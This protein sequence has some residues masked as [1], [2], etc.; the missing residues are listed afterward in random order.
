MDSEIHQNGVLHAHNIDMTQTVV[1]QECGVITKFVSFGINVIN[2][3]ATTI[4]MHIKHF[5]HNRC[6][7]IKDI[8]HKYMTTIFSLTNMNDCLARGKTHL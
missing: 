5:I 1:P 4:W 3:G 8:T 7:I 6:M 2:V